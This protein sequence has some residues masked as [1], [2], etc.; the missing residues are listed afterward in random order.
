[1]LV[2]T[3]TNGKK[4][5]Y[6]YPIS[7]LQIVKNI[8][9]ILSTRCVAVRINGKLTDL[10]NTILN[11]A[12]LEFITI[13]DDIGLQ[14]IKKSCAHLLG[15]AIKQLWPHAKMIQG[16][17]CKS[18]FYYDIDLNF[19]LTQQTLYMLQQQMLLLSNKK[20]NII[21]KIVS[22]SEAKQIFSDLGETYKILCINEKTMHAEFISLY[23]HEEYIDMCSGPH[24]PN[25]H[26]CQNFQLYKVTKINY[27]NIK[28]NTIIL[29]RIHGT[30]HTNINNQQLSD[31]NT[32]ILQ[33]LKKYDHRN[34]AHQLDLYH[35]QEN[36]PGMVF[37]HEN[38]LTIFQE[39]KNFIRKKLKKYKYKEVKSPVMID[40]SLWNK[41]GHWDNYQEHIFTTISENREYCIKPMNCPG[42]VQI[43]NY[44]IKSYKDLPFRIAE[45]GSCHRNEYS[46]SLHGLMRIREFT[47]DDAHIFCSEDQIQDELNHCIKMMY[48]VYH[49]FGFTNIIINLSTRP[50][51]R[52]GD[53]SKWD[54]AE[55]LLSSVLKENDITFQYQPYDGAF[56][57]PKIE[58]TLL[59]SLGRKWQCG[60]IQLDF[61]LSNLLD[62]HYIDHKNTYKNPVIIH[63]AILGSI[64]RFIGLLTEEYA[65]FFP[66]WLAPTQ[67]VLINVTHEQS[68]YVINLEKKL[69]YENIRVKTDLRNETIGFKIR[70]HTLHRVPYIL[71]CGNVE[72]NLGT[73]SIRTYKGKIIKNYDIN[74]F[75]EKLKNE[76]YNYSIHQLEE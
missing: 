71:I 73:I 51:R 60:T 21:K 52:I 41:T 31:S 62:I 25:I 48:D 35:I 49:A 11:D 74:M 37:W 3:L 18:G 50:K 6:K 15:Y 67:V 69:I 43:F 76:I 64:E 40:R 54:V 29:Q 45:F 39:L 33:K 38:G 47:Q 22:K 61:S 30:L 26:F 59:D 70:L 17:A 1:M 44:S 46:G 2:I 75:L 4:Y 53:E 14:I 7:P 65:G 16:S 56:Y 57:G 12:T 66:T 68:E 72:M 13:D 36:A 23:F 42:H 28:K 58:L 27:N 20:Y 32:R 10:F 55:Q 24:V 63:R 34:L 8:D 19:N 5:Q 9:P